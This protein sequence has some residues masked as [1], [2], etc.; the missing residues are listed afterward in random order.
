M[1]DSMSHRGDDDVG[2]RAAGSAAA[3]HRVRW[4]T[5]EAQSER[6]PL[7]SA[8]QRLHL[9]YDGRLD[10]RAEVAAVLALPSS[11]SDGQLLVEL[12][13]R[14][15]PRGLA[16]AVGEF[17]LACWCPSER[18]LWL[19]RDAFGMRP[20]YY[21]VGARAVAWASELQAVLQPGWVARR[22]NEGF[23]AEYLALSVST[24]DET[25]FADVWRL[26]P[27]H[28]LEVVNGQVSRWR[29]STPTPLAERPQRDDGAA[30][31]FRNVLTTAV[32]ACLRTI[33]QPAFQLSGGLDSS[34]VVMLARTRG[35]RSPS[36]FS[37]VYPGDPDTDESPFIDD[38]V[39]AADAGSVRLAPPVFRAD[40]LF[41][42]ALRHQDAPG[43][44][45]GEP[46][47]HPLLDAAAASGARAMLTGVGGDEWLN[48]SPFRLAR[49]IRRGRWG[50]AA[51]Y[52]REYRDAYAT[53]PHWFVCAGLLPLV[54][55][56][57]KQAFRSLVPRQ[58]DAPWIV[59][60]FA[61]RAGL[62]DRLR[63]GYDRTPAVAD[64][65][66][67]ESLERV[68]SGDHVH[69]RESLDRMGAH[70][71]IELRHPFLDR[72]VVEFLIGLP[73]DL[74]FRDGQAKHVLRAALA[75]SLPER[76]RL[77]PDKT[78]LNRVLL[79]AVRVA[80]REFTWPD[81]RV[82]DLGWVDAPAAR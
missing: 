50:A 26:P 76:V 41:E 31:N 57:A 2:V 81:L 75:G 71:G 74:R 23:W 11:T 44:P 45:V 64:R 6:Q 78:T 39:G 62:A 5:V 46:L 16:R 37:L 53:G 35:V 73:D 15:G 27:A 68:T 82:A 14:E 29:Y 70:A 56:W 43:L 19:A 13:G 80:A 42:P 66:V 61:R 20:L 40:A 4:T 25:P 51:R 67:R 1:L 52:A 17:A 58:V 49:L 28:V 10:N 8:D 60:A 34:S 18:R 63:A 69:A 79:A 65:V 36:T 21:A 33:G 3:G 54:P 9:V 55:V 72:R 22:P 47:M 30:E 12:L 77:R 24:V 7:V 32:D 59:P 48:G 38:V